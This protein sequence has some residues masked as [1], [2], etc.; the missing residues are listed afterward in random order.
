[1]EASSKMSSPHYLYGNAYVK[2]AEERQ[3]KV[4]VGDVADLPS[5]PCLDRMDKSI[6]A[7]KAAQCVDL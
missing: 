2:V 7:L 4:E 3:V 6:Q 5:C 1:M